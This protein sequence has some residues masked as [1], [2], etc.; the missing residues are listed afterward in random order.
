MFTKF[1]QIVNKKGLKYSDVAR[2]AG[3]AYSTITDWKAGRCTPKFDKM[4][5]IADFLGVPINVFY[6]DI[7]EKSQ[8][9]DFSEEEKE[10]ISKWREIDKDLRRMVLSSLDTALA[11]TRE[12]KKEDNSLSSEAV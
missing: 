2:G 1:E 10:I 5:K 11:M 3:I 4:Q 9:N 6:P 12:R 8:N 7:P